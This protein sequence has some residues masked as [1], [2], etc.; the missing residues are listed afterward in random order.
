MWYY[1][2]FS[3]YLEVIHIWTIF[4]VTSYPNLAF[5]FLTICSILSYMG[6]DLSPSGTW[7]SRRPAYPAPVDVSEHHGGQRGARVAP[8]FNTTQSTAARVTWHIWLPSVGP[9]CLWKDPGKAG[10]SKPKPKPKMALK[11]LY[12]LVVGQRGKIK[13]S[14]RREANRKLMRWIL[15]GREQPGW[16]PPEGVMKLRQETKEMTRP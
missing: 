9:S 3:I 6:T 10:R 2:Y 8:W 7:R 15:P 13:T 4:I 12:S 11:Y 1:N 5:F 14:F 16:S